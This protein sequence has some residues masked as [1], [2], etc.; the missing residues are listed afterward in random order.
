MLWG[1]IEFGQLTTEPALSMST[2]V[3]QERIQ[4]SAG[5]VV[6]QVNRGQ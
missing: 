1:M 2:H 6:C 3:Q 4:F 5:D